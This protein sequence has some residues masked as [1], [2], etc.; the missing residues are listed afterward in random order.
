MWYDDMAKD[1]EDPPDPDVECRTCGQRLLKTKAFGLKCT[2]Q[3]ARI[4]W[5]VK[6]PEAAKNPDA[7]KVH[8]HRVGSGVGKGSRTE[9]CS[10]ATI[11]GEVPMDIVP[12]PKPQGWTCPACGHFHSVRPRTRCSKCN[13]MITGG[14]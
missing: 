5:V 13:K 2:I 3:P 9:A 8:Y 10:G 6:N 4:V 12:K 14:T 7:L 11:Q 1:G